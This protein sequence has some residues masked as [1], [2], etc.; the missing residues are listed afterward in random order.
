M[1]RRTALLILLAFGCTV[2]FLKFS[3]AHFKYGWDWAETFYPA[4][5]LL[6]QGGNPYD[7]G[8][9][10]NPVWALFPLIPM[11]MLGPGRGGAAF[12]AVSFFCFAFA[13]YRLQRRPGS[14]VV[15]LLS[16]LVLWS[17]STCNI[18]GIVFAGFF[19]PPSVGLFFAAMKPQIG[20]IPAVLWTY[21]AWKLGGLRNVAR[22]YLPLLLA[23]AA[24]F[25]IYGN[26][27]AGRTDDMLTA[28][29]NLSLFPWSVP[30]GLFLVFL[31][32]RK[33]RYSG[34]IAASP[35]FSPYVG[36]QSM[37]VAQVAL[38][39]HG[40]SDLAATVVLWLVGAAIWWPR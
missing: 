13:A 25:L 32:F 30:V 28:W 38:I 14:L 20:F 16:P 36:L 15:F 2:W 23:L 27:F 31:A 18:D 1:S 9:L 7:V 29:W 8:T 34:A 4:T 33:T 26:W 17:V 40:F 10:H 6:L 12:L 37:W 19:L 11:A 22:I 24:T 3:E 35:F 5:K 21:Q 39:E